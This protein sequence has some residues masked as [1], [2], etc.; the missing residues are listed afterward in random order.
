MYAEILYRTSL[1]H[2]GVHVS[3]GDFLLTPSHST[4]A[5]TPPLHTSLIA[6]QSFNASCSCCRCSLGFAWRAEPPGK[7]QHVQRSS[8]H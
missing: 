1:C 2:S 3:M 4:V 5:T 6:A 7:K 8:H